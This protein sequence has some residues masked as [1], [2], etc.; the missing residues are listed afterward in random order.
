MRNGVQVQHNCRFQHTGLVCVCY[1][2]LSSI[3]RLLEYCALWAGGVCVCVCVCGGGFSPTC[4]VGATEGRGGRW[5][6]LGVWVEG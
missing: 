5:F 6:W 1:C 3:L 2:T 4:K